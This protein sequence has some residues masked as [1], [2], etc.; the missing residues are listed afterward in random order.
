MWI[1]LRQNIQDLIHAHAHV[2][3]AA[4]KLSCI[5]CHSEVLPKHSTAPFREVGWQ[6]D[7]S[8]HPHKYFLCLLKTVTVYQ[9][10]AAAPV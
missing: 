6:E 5:I 8:S 7:W 4:A 9:H 2:L 10:I 1:T 3:K